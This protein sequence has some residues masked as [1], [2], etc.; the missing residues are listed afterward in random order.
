MKAR[1]IPKAPYLRIF[2]LFPIICI[3]SCK[4][5]NPIENTL[6][7]E[8]FSTNDK[9]QMEAYFF[10]ATANLSKVIISKSQ[11]AQQKASISIIK[12]LG[13]KIENHQSNLLHDVAKIANKRLVIVTEINNSNKLE[14]YKLIDA[15]DV[16]FDK[17]FMNS[18]LESLNEQIEA[19][20]S[21]SKE[22]N[23]EVILKLVLHY[24][25]ELYRFLRETELIKQQI[26]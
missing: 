6:K 14:L 24:L 10:I 25:P 1:L 9:E 4:H 23:D 20:E 11:I 17:A 18:L 2:F 3:T 5:N 12:H 15:S 7:N 16:S 22:T 13:R 8:T 21:V 26:N 19:L